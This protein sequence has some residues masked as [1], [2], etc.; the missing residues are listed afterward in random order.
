[1]TGRELLEFGSGTGKHARLLAQM[2]YRITG[3]ERSATM[4]AQAQL[5]EGFQCQQGDICAV[6]LGRQFDA[7]LSLFHVVSYQV[8]NEALLALF[9]RAAEHLKSNGLFIFDIWYS[10]AVYAQRPDVRIKRMSDSDVEITRIAEPVI[11]P[12]ENRVDVNYTILA[13]NLATGD[14]QTFVETH[15]MRH[16]SLPELDLLAGLSGF[17][18]IA[19]EAFLTGDEPSEATWGVCLVLRK[20]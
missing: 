8:S 9:T 14:Y 4:V 13:R 18:R 12:N 5:S 10:P 3:I 2:D 19:A 7:V 6:R 16:F 1:I 17:H 20:T 11:Y 15:P